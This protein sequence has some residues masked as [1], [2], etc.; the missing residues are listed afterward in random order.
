MKGFF[1]T[2]TDTDVGKSVTAAAIT[3]ALE[4]CYWKPIQSGE[5]DLEKVKSLLPFSDDHYMPAVY[6]WKAAIS[7]DQ[8]AAI[9]NQSMNFD[10][11]KLPTTEKTLIVEGAG[12]IFTPI[13]KTSSMLDLM[14]KLGLP[15][16]ITA[17]GTLG[18]INHTLMTIEVLRQKKLNIQGIIFSGDLNPDNQIAIEERSGIKTL[19]HIPYFKEMTSETL[20]QWV[21][22]NKISIKA[23]LS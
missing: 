1:I 7:P 16:I 9:E 22:K 13:N 23:A 21:N 20:Q 2:G 18:T 14:K 4:G 3:L 15:I 5:P 12:G 6:S 8:A 19:M 17:R 10:V 11:F